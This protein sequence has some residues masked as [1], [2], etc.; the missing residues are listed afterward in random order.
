VSKVKVLAGSFEPTEGLWYKKAFLLYARGTHASRVGISTPNTKI[1]ASSLRTLE[2]ATEDNVKRVAGTAGWAT[3]GAL[4]LGPVGLIGGLLLGGRGKDITFV[5]E[6][7][8]GRKLLATVD[9]G[10][11]K[12]I[13]AAKGL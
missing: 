9:S 7:Y 11:Y 2:I 6:F 8:D 5:A 3:A 4:V 12:E 1:P 10:T 13:L